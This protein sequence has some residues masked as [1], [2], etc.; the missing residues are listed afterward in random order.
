MTE[1]IFKING[2]D[3]CTESFGNPKNP[4]I[5]L[6]MGATCSMVYWDEEFCEQLANSGAFVIRFDNRD[7]GRSVAYEPGTSNYSV[8]DMAEDAI[9]VLDA[10]HI[11]QAHLF[12]M[13]L[14]V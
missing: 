6:I 12:G 9:G 13:S 14:G 7:V 4:A 3:I 2:I 11:D 5:L 10:Y 8:T 1:K